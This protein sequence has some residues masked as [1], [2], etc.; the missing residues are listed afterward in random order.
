MQQY[1]GLLQR[2]EWPVACKGITFN[3][4]S[5]KDNGQ[6][7]AVNKGFALARGTILGWLNSDDTYLPGALATAVEFF[8][9]NPE[10][11]MVYG[12]AWYTDRDG[13]FTV[14]YR[15]EP[16]S[17]K[18]LAAKSI[19]CQPAAFLRREVLQ[20][21]GYLDANLHTC[22]DY[23]FWI[24]IGKAFEGRIVFLDD[25]LA[26]SRIYADNKTLSLRE[27][28]YHETML[29]ARRHFGYVPGVWIVHSILEVIQSSGTPHIEKIR[30]IGNRLYF[31]RFLLQPRTL[32]SVIGFIISRINKK[33]ATT[34]WWKQI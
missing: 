31:L 23:D 25:N 9:A 22:L 8:T 12:N 19:I 10:T 27:L 1:E 28:T 30:T 4:S 18:R 7:E 26:T 6:A 11:V 14:S 33:E 13:I 24:R 3:W 2:G 20:T 16:F 34:S 29:V 21:V 15:S 17:L 32:L 5:E